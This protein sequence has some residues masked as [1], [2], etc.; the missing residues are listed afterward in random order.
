METRAN[1]VWVG[2]VSLLLLAVMAGS[3]V[4]LARLGQGAQ[5]EYDILF[6][7]SVEGLARGSQV[8][9][10]GVPVGQVN[11]IELWNKDPEYVRVRIRIDDKVPVLV[12]TKASV[13]ASFTGVSTIMLDGAVKDAPAITCET[14]SCPDGLPVIPPGRGGFGEI[15]ANAPLL[16]ER[17]ATLTERMTQVLDENNQREIAGILRN[18]NTLTGNLATVTPQISGTLTELQLTLRESREALLGFEQIMSSTDQLVNTEGYAIAAELRGTLA[19]ANQAATS[20]TATLEQTQPISQQ[21]SQDT[22]P[23]VEATLDDLR[24][25]SKAL[26]KVTER[27]ENQGLGALVEGQKLP[28][29]EP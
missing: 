10:S 28:D 13:L 5:N 16:L 2:L 26:R 4:W 15:V 25:T 3:I 23:A 19:A 27:L 21:L 14:T 11:E 1:H 7:Q 24:A 20:L 9:F 12:G 18:T 22:L 17:I 29:Y 6:K 8:T